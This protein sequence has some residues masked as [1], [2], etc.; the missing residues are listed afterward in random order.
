MKKYI[1]VIFYI[2]SILIS[3]SQITEGSNYHVDNKKNPQYV[4]IEEIK[5][6]DVSSSFLLCL[7]LLNIDKENKN[8]STH[9]NMTEYADSQNSILNQFS[10]LMFIIDRMKIQENKYKKFLIS[11]SSI[12]LAFPTSS[13]GSFL[14]HKYQL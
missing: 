13:I 11:G 7:F 14:I 10:V 8:M 2:C 1:T 12:Q 4:N 5:T 3:R 9:M 6:I